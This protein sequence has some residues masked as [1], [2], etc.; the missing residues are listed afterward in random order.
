MALFLDARIRCSVPCVVLT[1]GCEIVCLTEG[2]VSPALYP[3]RGFCGP[4]YFAPL[5]CPY[6]AC[7]FLVFY[8]FGLRSLHCVCV[9]V[10]V[11]L[12][13][14]TCTGIALVGNPD[15]A[16]V[17]EA[18]PYIARRLLTDPSP[19]LREA[20]RYMVYGKSNVFDA[21]GLSA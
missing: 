19:R 5:A 14:C 1:V 13:V 11:T 20:L 18:Y 16:I 15:F 21:G 7:P 3:C 8:E 4:P 9:C 10:C 12:C 2:T 17:D 6:C